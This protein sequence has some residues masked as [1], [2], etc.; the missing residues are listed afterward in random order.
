MGKRTMTKM[1]DSVTKIQPIHPRDPV[2]SARG[3]EKVDAE[4]HSWM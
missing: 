2:R 4:A 1:V 3:I